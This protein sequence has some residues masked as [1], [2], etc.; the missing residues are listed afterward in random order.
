M[1]WPQTRTTY[2]HVMKKHSRLAIAVS[3]ALL[4]PMPL[5]AQA[6]GPD[7][8][9]CTEAS[10]PAMLVRV[11]G[12]KDRAGKVRVRSFG[13]SPSTYF[14]K[15]QTLRRI[16]LPVPSKGN[17]DVCVP[18]PAPGVYAVDVRHDVN[19]NGKTDRADG[20]GASGNPKITLV[21]MIFK[22]KPPVKQV[23]V[24]VGSGVTVVPVQIKYLSGG[25][26]KPIQT[27][28]R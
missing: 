1:F 2:A 20:G 27:A 26:F 13:G 23:Q 6:I 17:V 24:A 15:K 5:P 10:G 7:S 12:L 28:G 22:R 19:D 16:E 25:S 14:D 4:A 9:V 21:D 18:V 3:A 11:Q 8:R